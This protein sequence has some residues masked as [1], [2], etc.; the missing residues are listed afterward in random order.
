MQSVYAV[1]LV[2]VSA[3]FILVPCV[4]RA[5]HAQREA[6]LTAINRLIDQYAQTDDAGDMAAQAELMTADRVY[7]GSDG[8]RRT[9]QGLNMRSQ[10]ARIDE[11][12]KLAPNTRWFSEGRDRL[13]RFYGNGTVAVASFYF[14]RTRVVPGDLPPE[15]VRLLGADPPPVAI[16]HVLVKEGGAWRIAHT[17]VTPMIPTGF[18]PARP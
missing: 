7:V 8:G 13:I 15:K 1:R 18:V 12:K 9:D 3:A 5:G 17:Q 2:A 14:Y 11:L 10:Q 16:T 4:A 6:D